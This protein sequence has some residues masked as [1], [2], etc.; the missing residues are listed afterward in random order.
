M[1]VEE[2]LDGAGLRPSDIDKVLLVGGSTRMPM[3]AR[4]LE[5][6]LDQRPDHSIHPDEAVARGAAILA[7]LHDAE[8]Q[9]HERKLVATHDVGVADVISHGL[10]VVSL[11][12]R[13]DQLTNSVLIAANTTIPCQ[14][15]RTFYTVVDSQTELDVQVTEG[16]E[17][18][19][20]Y[21]KIL[22]NSILKIPPYPR[23]APVGVVL[24]AD[25]DGILHVEVVDETSG[26]GL[27]EFEIDR[28]FNLNE[29][30]VETMRGALATLEVQ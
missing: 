20:R 17:A 25:I 5:R 16:D 15:K 6:M 18:S 7:D 8:Q 9:G 26:R 13:T 2:V 10:G 28:Q 22:G 3:V 30:D 29:S 11:D 24:S 21:T 19:L 14:K 27:G 12:A 1:L 23:G 4:T